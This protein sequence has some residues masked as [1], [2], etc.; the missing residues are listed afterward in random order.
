MSLAKRWHALHPPVA[1]TAELETC[2]EA[3]L[4]A[5]RAANPFV[6][7]PDDE[8]IEYLA[9]RVPTDMPVA[10]A[11]AAICVADLYLAAGLGR[12]DGAA[13]RMFEVTYLAGLAPAI[14]HLAGGTAL[15]DDVRNA[16]RER[17]LPHGGKGKIGEYQG[18]GDLRGW[19]RVVAVREALQLVRARRREAPLPDDLA[20]RLAVDPPSFT[21]EATYRGA[22]TIALAALGPRERNLLR[23]HYMHGATVA[24]I[25]SLY[26]VHG[27]TAARWIAQIRETLLTRTRRAVGEA[28]RLSG[29][30]LD[31]AMAKAADHL[32]Y[33]LRHTLS[34]EH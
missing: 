1:V 18:R 24:E 34:Y 33:S 12:G 28:L 26:G 15:A 19:L 21:N 10:E 16:V 9:A 31:S 17:V 11:L 30:E 32:D 6:D 29:T 5:S 7:V 4:A 25:G 20:T 27:A 13:L 23:Q 22:F 8:F 3:A 2:L 14:A